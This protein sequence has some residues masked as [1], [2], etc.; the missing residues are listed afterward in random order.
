MATM[1]ETVS[2]IRAEEERKGGLLIVSARYGDLSASELD[3]S[4]AVSAP[5]IDVS[6]P[7]QVGHTH[8]WRQESGGERR[9]ERRWKREEASCSQ[10]SCS[11]LLCCV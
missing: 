1:E 6:V 4:A 3:A 9:R 2:Q 7:L 8:E 11:A 10:A 5:W